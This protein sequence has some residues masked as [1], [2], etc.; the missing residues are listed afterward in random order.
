M[1]LL[2]AFLLREFKKKNHGRKI[3]IL[4]HQI[5]I[6]DSRETFR[7]FLKLN[8]Y[9]KTSKS[10]NGFFKFKQISN[11]PCTKSYSARHLF[12]ATIKEA[13]TFT[14]V[15]KMRIFIVLNL[16]SCF[17]VEVTQPFICCDGHV[18]TEIF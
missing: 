17:V 1:N 15:S 2:F 10:S 13:A 14:K 5:N 9:L 3:F 16:F 7:A 6:K 12:P 18:W 8:F 11:E 4:L